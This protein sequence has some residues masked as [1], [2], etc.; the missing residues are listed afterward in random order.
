VAVLTDI[1][2]PHRGS[3]LRQLMLDGEPWRDVCVDAIR[4]LSLETG[5]DLDP[6]ELKAALD[7]AE[8]E[9][10][11]ERALRLLTYKERS[12]A[13]L[14][15]RLTDDGYPPEVAHA[16]VS[17]LARCGFV[18]DERFAHAFA[19]TLT[20]VRGLG[21]TRALRDLESA[22]IAPDLALIAIDEALPP[23][24]EAESAAHLAR[25]AAARPGATVDRI[26]SRLLRRGYRPAVALA[27]ARTALEAAGNPDLDS[28]ADM[29][30][31]AER[32]LD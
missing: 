15:A 20:R 8:P 24:A 3:K 32:Y 6:R 13:G 30:D 9:C 26:A 28:D 10:A 25:T 21:R 12:A 14:T 11:R 7:E 2:T 4:R 29:S 18:D 17:D 19:R 16:V 23:D 22:G 31:A 1:R 5:A 27:A